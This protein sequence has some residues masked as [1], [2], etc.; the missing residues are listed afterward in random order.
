MLVQ[1]FGIIQAVLL[2]SHWLGR[3]GRVGWVDTKLAL[4]SFKLRTLCFLLSLLTGWLAFYVF[5]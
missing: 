2:S 1:E 4:Q 3:A 5:S